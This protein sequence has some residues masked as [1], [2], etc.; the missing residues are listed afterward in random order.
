M[1]PKPIALASVVC[2]ITSSLMWGMYPVLGRYLMHRQAGQ[3]SAASVLAVICFWNSVV[4]GPYY[5]YTRFCR[6]RERESAPTEKEVELIEK[7]ED[8][9]DEEELVIDEPVEKVTVTTTR[10]MQV[11][12]AYGLL[13]LCRMMTNMQSVSMT[14]AYLTQITA[15]SLPF[16]TAILARLYLREKIHT[17]LYPAVF[18]MIAG[19]LLVLHDQGAFVDGGDFLTADIYGIALQLLSVFF[20]AMLKIAFKGTEGTLD[21]IELLLAQFLITAVPLLLWS[22]LMERASLYYMFTGLDVGGWIALFAMSVGIYM[23]GNYLQI[24]AVRSL[25]ASNHSASNSIRLLSAVAGSSILLHE[26]LQGALGYV[27]CL[28]IMLAVSGYWYF[29]HFRNKKSESEDDEAIVEKRDVGEAAAGS[30][31]VVEEAETDPESDLAIV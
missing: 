4:V 17:A 8:K 22:Y 6:E 26:D 10:K 13:C 2:S 16:F 20:S 23:V 19:S 15:M 1:E 21:T 25:G 14:K 5:L 24:L 12:F 31:S 9:M 3:P 27:G 18:V 11:A 28:L 7:G 29:V 30:Y